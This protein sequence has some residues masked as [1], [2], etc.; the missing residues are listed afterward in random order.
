MKYRRYRL[1]AGTTIWSGPKGTIIRTTVSNFSI[2]GPRKKKKEKKN[3]KF[4]RLAKAFL[5]PV[6]ECNRQFY[7]FWSREVPSAA[8]PPRALQ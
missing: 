5:I 4:R 6:A 2:E 1:P 7:I 8:T 3:E